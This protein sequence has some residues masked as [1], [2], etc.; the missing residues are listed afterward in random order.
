MLLFWDAKNEEDEKEEEKKKIKIKM[1]LPQAWRM[2]LSFRNATVMVCFLNVVTALLLLQGF[3]SSASSRS[4][5]S[6]SQFNSG[7]SV[8]VSLS[9][10]LNFVN[11]A[12]NFLCQ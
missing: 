12:V 10:L 3:I 8:S 2:R 6:A 11:T 7:L 1:E 5:I 9:L 4:K